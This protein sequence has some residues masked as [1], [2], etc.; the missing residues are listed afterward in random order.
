MVI[1]NQYGRPMSATDAGPVD[2]AR[3]P[4]APRRARLTNRTTGLGG[5]GD[6][7]LGAEFTAVCLDRHAAERLYQMSWTS[8][9][10]VRTIVD[11]MFAAGRRWT[12]EDES[13]NKAMV[14][15]A[16]AGIDP[17]C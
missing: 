4:S 13:A 12:G 3:G 10:L 1:L 8:K 11:D 9:R 14:P 16:R 7:S 17:D 5:R 2:S 6:K 15:T